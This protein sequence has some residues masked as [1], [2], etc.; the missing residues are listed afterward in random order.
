MWVILLQ[1]NLCFPNKAS[2]LLYG[3]R[4]PQPPEP[5]SNPF[6]ISGKPH[7]SRLKVVDS[8]FLG[9]CTE[10]SRVSGSEFRGLSSDT[11]SWVE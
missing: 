9:V 8:L 6:D 5:I 11:Q 4:T 2:L 1:S 10:M 7:L 3:V